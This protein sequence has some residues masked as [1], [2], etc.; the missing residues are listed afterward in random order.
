MSKQEKNIWQ[1]LEDLPRE[2]IYGLLLIAFIIPMINPIGLPLPI[3]P[4]VQKWYDTI[5]A[6]PS[7][8]V[9]GID[10]GYSGGGEPELGPFAVAVFNHIFRKGGVKTICWA[11]SN[12]GPLLFDRALAEVKPE[13]YGAKYGVDYIMLGYFAGTETAMAAIAKNIRTLT[14]TDY[15]ATPLDQYPVMQG[16]NDASAFKIVICYTTGQDQSEGYVRQWVTAYKTPYLSC[17]LALMIPAMLPYARSGQA[18]SV[19]AGAQAG[20]METLVKVPARGVA[21]ADVMTS[22]ELLVSAFVILGNIAYF[23][24]VQS[25]KKALGG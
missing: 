20:Q 2:V 11:T 9:I 23:A 4:E 12:E 7:G 25:K 6:L 1:K 10:M 17:V 15:K 5:Q 16:V 22:T 13:Q 18:V 21:S 8:S 3:T 14:S 24:R 19:T